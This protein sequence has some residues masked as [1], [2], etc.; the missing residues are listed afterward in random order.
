[1]STLTHGAVPTTAN[2]KSV[3]G[4][5]ALQGEPSRTSSLGMG[6]EDFAQARELTHCHVL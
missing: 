6:Q 2:S 5:Q 3:G 1:M 4:A